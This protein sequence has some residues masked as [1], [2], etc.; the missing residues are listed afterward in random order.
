LSGSSVRIRRSSNSG[1]IGL[2]PVDSRARTDS[3]ARFGILPERD[4]GRMGAGHEHNLR[5]SR[6][7]DR[8]IFPGANL[9]Q[10]THVRITSPGTFVATSVVMGRSIL[11]RL[12]KL[13][14][15]SHEY[16]SHHRVRRICG[17][18]CRRFCRS[19]NPSRDMPVDRGEMSATCRN[20][21]SDGRSTRV[22]SMQAFWTR[23]SFNNC[24]QSHGGSRIGRTARARL[25]KH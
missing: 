10:P 7:L 6:L 5:S 20:S 11:S 22:L 9:T 8:R 16:G 25:S 15:Q 1:A 19:S 3:A 17:G 4:N 24:R 2:V 23:L 14:D 13:L 21:I 12:S 18:N